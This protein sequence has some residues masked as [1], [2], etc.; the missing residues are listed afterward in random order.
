MP[1]TITNPDKPKA[2]R[3]PI[4]SDLQTMAKIE[5]LMEDLTKESQSRVW[6]WFIQRFKSEG[7][8]VCIENPPPDPNV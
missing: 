6:N 8:I 3:K 5:R 2:K 7:L 1:Q 4:G